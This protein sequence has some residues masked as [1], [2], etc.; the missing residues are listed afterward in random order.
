MA[1]KHFFELPVETFSGS[2]VI[3][4]VD[5]TLLADGAST[6]DS[7]TKE[8][9]SKLSSVADVYLCS[10]AEPSE[11][12]TTLAEGTRAKVITAPYKKPDPRLLAQVLHTPVTCVVI[13]DKYLTDGL[14]AINCGARFLKVARIRGEKERVFVRLTYLLD[15]LFGK[16][17]CSLARLL[18]RI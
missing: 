11:R 16:V 1:L 12:L 10:N 5:G 3:L 9:L 6:L 14:L 4:D 2:T 7:R 17:V 13:G 15:A 8:T 18:P